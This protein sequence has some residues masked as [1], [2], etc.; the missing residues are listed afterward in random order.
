MEKQKTGFGI[1]AL[2]LGIVGLV[3]SFIPIINNL[4]FFLGILGVIFGIVALVTHNKKGI[5]IAGLVTGILAMVITLSLQASWAKS[6]NEVSDSLNEVSDSLSDMSGENTEQLIETAVDIQLGEF[7]A[8]E[9]KWDSGL[10]VTI[11]NLTDESASFDITI[12]AINADG[13]RLGTDW[14]YVQ[15]LRA[16]Q[17]TTKEVFNLLSTEDYE[18]YRNATFTI[19][20][21]SKY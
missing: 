10:E 20:E 15:D 2:V 9:S 13:D 12:E 19:L 16:G 8:D 11:T 6:L 18:D 7:T 4:A 17:S 3:L 21:V 5:S 1:T 14:I